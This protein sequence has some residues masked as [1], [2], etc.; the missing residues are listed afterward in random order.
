MTWW[1]HMATQIWINNASSN[2]LLSDGTQTLPEPM[3]TYRQ[4]G[5]MT[6]TFGQFYKGPQPSTTEMNL[7]IIY[8]IFIRISP[9][10]I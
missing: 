6:I 3:L 7:K 5:P 10:I 4:W 2:G 1:R 9:G 8:K